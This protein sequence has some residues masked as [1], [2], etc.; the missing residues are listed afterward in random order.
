MT[1]P[2]NPEHKASAAGGGG[3]ILQTRRQFAGKLAVLA[4]SAGSRQRL[5]EQI[6]SLG[7]N[8]LLVTPGSVRTGGVHLGAGSRT[9][10]T[11]ADSDA[12]ANPRLRPI[13]R[14]SSEAGIVASIVARNWTPRGTVARAAWGAR[15]T[16]TRAEVVTSRELLVM[17]RA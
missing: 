13:R 4:V 11:T 12:S 2:A 14:I 10:L 1:E 15:A 8:L 16:P 3:P 6:Q 5:I 7:G 17:S 9:A